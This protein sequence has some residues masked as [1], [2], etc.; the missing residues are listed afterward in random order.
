MFNDHFGG[1]LA[2]FSLVFHVV[3]SLLMSEFNLLHDMSEEI[4]EILGNSKTEGKQKR[5]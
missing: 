3:I 4:K 5:V 1:L 2:S